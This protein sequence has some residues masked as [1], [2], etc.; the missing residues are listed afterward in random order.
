MPRASASRILLVGLEREDDV[1]V[2]LIAFLLVA[3][4][5]RDE[6]RRHVFVVARAASVEI[7]VLLDELEGIGG[8]V[9][10]L[11]FDDVDMGEEEDRLARAGAVQPGDEVALARRRL[12]H[13]HVG[14]GKACGAQPRRHR[15]GGAGGVAGLGDRVD[16][17]ELLVDVDGALLAGR[18]GIGRRC[19]RGERRHRERRQAGHERSGHGVVPSDLRG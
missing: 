10:R 1:A 12:E 6:R 5:V 13:L 4:H 18:Q 3:D 15:V 11:R 8:P 17:D 16:L 9:L 2:G 14:V 7:A 19:R